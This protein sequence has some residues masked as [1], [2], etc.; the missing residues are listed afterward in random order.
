MKK[1]FLLELICAWFFLLF[2]YTGI[3]KLLTYRT[4]V[5][6]LGRDPLIGH[7]LAVLIGI[8]LPVLE[9]IIGIMLLSPP[10]RKK[11]LYGLLILLASFTFYIR[12]MLHSPIRHCTC[13]GV[14]RTMTWK[15]HFWFNVGCVLLSIG[16]IVICQQQNKL[17]S[18]ASVLASLK[19]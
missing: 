9:I 12:Y 14:L 4:F 2:I 18:K 17:C 8:I 3:S 19:Q 6:D 10:Q 15:Q 13:G 7:T 11:G 1:A 16:G 5:W